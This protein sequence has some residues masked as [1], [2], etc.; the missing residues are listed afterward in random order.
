MKTLRDTIKNIIKEI[1]IKDKNQYASGREHVIF[2]HYNKPNRLIKVGDRDTVL[3]WVELFKSH[4]N[5]FPKIYNIREIK[6]SGNFYVE[7]EK[8]DAKNFENDYNYL[9]KSLRSLGWKG[10]L[11]SLYFEY[12]YDHEVLRKI[13]EIL[14]RTDSRAYDVF[15]KIFDL[16]SKLEPISKSHYGDDYRIDFNEGNYGYTDQGELKCLDI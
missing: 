2:K 12:G 1:R 11:E 4:P 16:L 8:L 9:E 10:Y 13:E 3:K 6:N 7:I 5:L 14:K 15:K